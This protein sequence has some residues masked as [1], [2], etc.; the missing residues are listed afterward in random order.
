MPRVEAQYLEWEV[1]AMTEIHTK[2]THVIDQWLGE[3]QFKLTKQN[4]IVF[5][6]ILI[7]IG[8]N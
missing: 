8:P 2:R 4:D 1:A 3:H 5:S 6:L 7:L